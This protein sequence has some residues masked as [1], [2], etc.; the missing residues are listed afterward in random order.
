MRTVHKWWPQCCSFLALKVLF[1][2]R[3]RLQSFLS[4]VQL[5]FSVTSLPC[6]GPLQSKRVE[7]GRPSS[8]LRSW[9]RAWWQF[10]LFTWFREGHPLL[11][12][13]LIGLG[14]KSWWVL[15]GWWSKGWWAAMSSRLTFRPRPLD[16]HKKLPIIKSVKDLDSGEGV[17]RT[18]Q[19]NHIALDA[20]NELV[21]QS[22]LSLLCHSSHMFMN[23]TF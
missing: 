9:D 20:E 2:L 19:H 14:C 12:W 6:H 10:I 18:V 4:R 8:I 1:S 23:F 13:A 3:S 16:I 21:R 11:E 17:S 15:G 5:L 22:V 7:V